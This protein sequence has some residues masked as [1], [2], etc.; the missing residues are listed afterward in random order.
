M[1]DRRTAV[2]AVLAR[3]TRPG[4][5]QRLQDRIVAWNVAAQRT[6]RPQY[7]I[8]RLP[9]AET[10]P[11]ALRASTRAYHAEVALHNAIVAAQ[12][13]FDVLALGQ[14]IVNAHGTDAERVAFADRTQIASARLL[15]ELVTAARATD[16]RQGM[17]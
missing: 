2:A 4:L 16:V 7:R 5:L 17:N 6:R 1:S 3:V 11:P 13:L 15:E 8:S 14:A 12:E 10:M 9:A